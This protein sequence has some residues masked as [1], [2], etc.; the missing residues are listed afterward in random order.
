MKEVLHGSACAHTGCSRR[1]VPF[2][3]IMVDLQGAAPPAPPGPPAPPPG[4][5]IPLIPGTRGLHSSTFR[6]NVSAFCAIGGAFRGC[7]GDVEE[8]LGNIKGC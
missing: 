4:P 3:F 7:I 8:V 2:T 5:I 6:L 1:I